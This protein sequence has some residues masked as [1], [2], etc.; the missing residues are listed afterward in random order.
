MPSEKLVERAGA[1]SSGFERVQSR[2]YPGLTHATG[3]KRDLTHATR[4]YPKLRDLD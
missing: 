3:S 1:R 2:F 4:I